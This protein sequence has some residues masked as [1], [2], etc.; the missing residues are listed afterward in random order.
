MTNNT[1]FVIDLRSCAVHV[2]GTIVSPNG[3]G[4]KA[5]PRQLEDTVDGIALGKTHLD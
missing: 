5:A 3:E 2:W 4:M 1:L